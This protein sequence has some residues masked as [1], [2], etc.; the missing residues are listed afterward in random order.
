MQSGGVWAASPSEIVFQ[1]GNAPRAQ[2]LIGVS[3]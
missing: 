1:E 2:A 3:S